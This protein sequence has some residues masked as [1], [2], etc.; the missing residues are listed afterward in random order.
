MNLHLQSVADIKA[1]TVPAIVID[2]RS[3]TVLTANELFLSTCAAGRTPPFPLATLGQLLGISTSA[4]EE[5]VLDVQP[6]EMAL[7]R[8]P[9]SR[10]DNGEREVVASAVRLQED[11]SAAALLLFP[12][13][14]HGDVQGRDVVSTAKLMAFLDSSF[15]ALWELDLTTDRYETST[16]QLDA[17]LG[18][19]PGTFPRRS[20]AW[21]ERVHPADKQEVLDGMTRTLSE[22]SGPVT[23]EYRIRR[24]DGSWAIVEDRCVMLPCGPNRE[25]HMVGATRDVTVE[26]EGAWALRK[27]EALYRALFSTTTN[28]AFQFTM[29]A[30]LIDANRAAVRYFGATG[31]D[32]AGRPLAVLIGQPAAAVVADVAA[33]QYVTTLHIE[34]GTDTEP[35][36]LLL[37]V[38]PCQTDEQLTVFGIGVDVT[39]QR[40][41]SCALQQSERELRAQAK[42]LEETN[43]ALRVV[44]EQ[45]DWS[46]RQVEKTVTE[47][48]DTLAIPLLDRLARGLRGRPEFIQVS[49]VVST[50][51]DIARPLRSQL[52]GGLQVQ[53]PLTPREAEV[54]AL[55]KRGLTNE[56]IASSLYLSVH[57]V[58]FHRA[59]LRRKL[60]LTGTKRHLSTCLLLGGQS[61]LVADDASAGTPLPT[62]SA[63]A[64]PGVSGSEAPRLP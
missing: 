6:G 1:L 2:V 61:S 36:D 15:D 55:V 35:K 8:L 53:E 17:I 31:R 47:N 18:F 7:S 5:L 22:G 14:L 25:S 37:T 19:S 38:V 27:S 24:A 21:L 28:P 56:Q 58:A 52:V 3:T 26:R 64:P 43:V 59:H 12:S 60:G 57:T 10:S 16:A 51:R 29:D 45:A 4:L 50:L 62:S 44:L 34:V 41:L 9:S 39:E 48:L 23:Q 40:Q 32:L 63:S 11:D 30:R 13:V 42:A 54:F 33:R 20:E 46:R 49:T